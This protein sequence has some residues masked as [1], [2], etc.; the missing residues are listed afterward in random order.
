MNKKK[1]MFDFDNT[2]INAT[3]KIVELYDKDF[4]KYKNYRKLHWTNIN[5]YGFEE[6]T[7][8]NRD[9]ILNYFDDHRFFINL[10]YNENAKEILDELK[11]EYNITICS[12]GRKRNLFFKSEW[13]GKNLPYANFIG[14]ELDKEDKSS[15]DMSDYLVMLD[16]NIDMLHSSNIKHKVIYGDILSWNKDNIYNYPRCFN[17][18]EFRDFLK[19][20]E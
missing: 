8:I 13:I 20:L 18:Y 3:K 5:T 19:T 1:L 10:E 14:I 6:L 11:D 15:V 16:D 12:L 2:I 9:I 17:W 7:L 4:C